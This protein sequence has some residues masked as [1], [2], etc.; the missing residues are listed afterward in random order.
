MYQYLN[1]ILF[2]CC[3]EGYAID[4][5]GLLHLRILDCAQIGQIPL[6]QHVYLL[7]DMSF[8]A[9]CEIKSLWVLRVFTCCHMS[10]G[11]GVGCLSST[12]TSC[13]C[14]KI[15]D[16]N[17]AEITPIGMRISSDLYSVWPW[18]FFVITG[19]FYGITNNL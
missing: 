17:S 7:K 3:F 4:T 6:L 8:S 10:S 19:Y 11:S 12:V 13:C 15:Y 9:V 16:R 14:L 1:G 5:Y 2:V 18:L